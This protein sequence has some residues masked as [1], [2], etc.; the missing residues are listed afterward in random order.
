MAPWLVLPSKAKQLPPPEKICRYRIIV[1]ALSA[2]PA[3]VPATNHAELQAHERVQTPEP[4]VHSTPEKSPLCPSDSIARPCSSSTHTDGAHCA[5]SLPRT[6]VSIAHETGAHP[7]GGGG[8]LGAGLNGGRSGGV[9]GGG[10]GE[11]DGGALGG[12]GGGCASKLPDAR[13]STT[14]TG[15]SDA[16][17]SRGGGGALGGRSSR[18]VICVLSNAQRLL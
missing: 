17:G 3:S 6:R 16:S 9:G 1:A 18:S 15:S 12:L 5:S 7:C 11:G 13:T 4:P 10:G 2:P 8:G 14:A